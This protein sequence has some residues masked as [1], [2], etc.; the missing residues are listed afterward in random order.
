M[1]DIWKQA[2]IWKV[3]TEWELGHGI[4]NHSFALPIFTSLN[5]FTAEKFLVGGGQ[6]NPGMLI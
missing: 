2:A 5:Y 1:S 3:L 6:F 4:Q